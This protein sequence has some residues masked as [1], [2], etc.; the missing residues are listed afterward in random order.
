MAINGAAATSTVSEILAPAQPE[1]R[2]LLKELLGEMHP[3]LPSSPNPLA[4]LFQPQSAAIFL[5]Q[6]TDLQQLFTENDT[7]EQTISKLQDSI[8]K[9]EATRDKLLAKIFDQLRPVERAYRSIDMFFE[10]ARVGS[11]PANA[12]LHILNADPSAIEFK[13]ETQE[14]IEAFIDR[15]NNTFNFRTAICNLVIPGFLPGN[16]QDAFEKLASDWGMLLISDL[17]DHRT[18]KDVKNHFNVGGN[19]EFLTRNEDQAAAHVAL[20]GWLQAREKYGFEQIPGP[21]G[22][23]KR[24]DDGLYIPPSLVFAGAIVRTDESKGII[25]GPIGTR[26]GQVVGASKCRIEPTRTAAEDLS[27][28]KQV[29]PIIRDANN[30]LCF[31][32]CRTLA[33][34]PYGVYKFFTSYR[35]IRHIEK[36][37]RQVL[38]A[39]AGVV[40]TR[41]AVDAYVDKPLRSFLQDTVDN[42]TLITFKLNIDRDSR[43]LMQGICDVECEVL[44]NGP[45]ETFIL[46]LDTPDFSAG[47]DNQKKD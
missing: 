45:G 43:K 3:G 27:M 17:A 37:A 46:K 9:A 18:M 36:Q 35:A 26:F 24:G 19:Y 22:D 42:G 8:S 34:D 13:K 10:N 29:I 30:R 38:Q 11:A 14:A 33:F 2:A 12:E 4:S 16:L 23:E 31:Y 1:T 7:Y 15:R 32:G 41:D 47:G 25:Q 21:A 28:N 39:A 5:K 20:V 44:P 40:L 6:L